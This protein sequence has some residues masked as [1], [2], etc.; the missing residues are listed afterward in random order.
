[1]PPPGS[2][3]AARTALIVDDEPGIGEMLAEMVGK[4]GYRS[5]VKASGEAAQAALRERDY[6]AVLCDLRLPGLDGR[7]L[8]DWMAEFRPY[9]CARIAF[10]TADTS[11]ASSH[12][13][14]TR[15][16]RPVLE[17]PFRPVDLRQL[18]SQLALDPQV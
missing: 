4:L 5:E 2:A 10:I 9:L 1:M 15:V 8:Y 12:R 7:A 17:K 11:S 16:G 18:L 14:L 3:S 13:F 6:D